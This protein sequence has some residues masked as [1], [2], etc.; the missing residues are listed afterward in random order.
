MWMSNYSLGNTK[1]VESVMNSNEFRACVAEYEAYTDLTWKG[2]HGAASQFWIMYV[3]YIHT[4][5]S[6]SGPS[7][8]MT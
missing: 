5:L 3:D 1:Q 8:P 7:E 2:E 6:L 4:F